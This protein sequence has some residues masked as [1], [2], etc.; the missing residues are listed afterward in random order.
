MT[1][2]TG[3]LSNE[4]TETDLRDAF[5]TYGEVSFVNIIQD[6][7][8]KIQVGFGMVGMPVQME[9]QAAIAGMN[10]KELKGKFL[11]VN[12]AGIRTR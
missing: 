4:I 7:F 11:V 8:H 6:R 5:K 9:A 10:G 1:I 12:E 3:N 2:Y